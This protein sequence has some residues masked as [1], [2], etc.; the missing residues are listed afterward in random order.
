VSVYKPKRSPYW[1]YDFV[2]QG[3]RFHGSTGQTT[4]RA[5]EAVEAKLRRAEGLGELDRKPGPRI[6]TLDEA[7]QELWE[8]R[9]KHQKSAYLF[10]ARLALAVE[11]VGADK[12]V[13]EVTALDIAEAI[14]LRR[15]RLVFAG[16][17]KPGRVPAPA[18]VNRDVVEAIRPILRRQRKLLN[19]DPAT[20]VS[21]PEIDWGELTLAEPRPRARDYAGDE[22]EA[23]VAALPPWWRDFAR[24]M[25]R[26]G[27]RLSEMF[28]DL[29]DVDVAGRRLTLRERKGDD[30]HVIPLLAEDAALLAARLGRA[31]AARLGTVWFRELK[32]GRLVALHY[33]GGAQAIRRAMREAGLHAA[34]GAKGSH[35]F[36]HHAAMTLLRTTR[37]L[38]TTQ[39]LLGHASLTSTLVYA[40]ALEDDVRAGI[41]AV[42]RAA[43]SGQPAEKSRNSPEQSGTD[44][45]QSLSSKVIG[46]TG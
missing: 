11:L 6:P 16:K 44:E 46:E 7:A 23:V 15:G 42:A 31:R 41:E 5:A 8:F 1:H 34:K 13:N 27:C 18:T 33:G 38:R 26:Y 14:R 29:A 21:F 19:S 9:W 25:A 12:P 35:D 28:F 3:R 4:R 45:A 32:G 17:G 20:P 30:D 40:H 22:I 43:A 37:N 24:F 36:R 10:E 2:R 39:R